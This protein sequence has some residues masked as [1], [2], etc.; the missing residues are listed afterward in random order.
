MV[1][2]VGRECGREAGL[3]VE[4]GGVSCSGKELRD[5]HGRRVL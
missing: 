1:Q 2:L 3:W 4:A 5:V